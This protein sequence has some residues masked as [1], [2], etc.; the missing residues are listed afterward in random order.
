M[1]FKKKMLALTAPVAAL[2]LSACATGFPAQVQR[3]Q[4]MPA[5]QGQTFVIQPADPERRGSLEFSQYADLVRRNL[6]EMGY[7]EAASAE[8]AT[9]VVT[10]DYGVDDGRE[11]VVARPDPFGYGF[12]YRP[13]YSRF[14]YFGHRRHPFYWGWH[15]PFMF[16]GGGYDIDSYTLY[17]SFLDMDIRRTADGQ[18]LFEGLAQARSR[19]NALPALVPNLVEAMFTNFPGNSGETVR[20]T[21]APEREER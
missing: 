18:A 20:I 8:G 19:S 6:I 1:S 16:G 3:F 7:A 4:A 13:Y 14:G 21:V 17:T 11:R 9:M 2:A 5:P 15:D 12:G 10:L